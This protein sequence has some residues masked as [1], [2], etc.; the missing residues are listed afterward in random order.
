MFLCTLYF[1]GQQ[2]VPIVNIWDLMPSLK[3]KK[4]QDEWRRRQKTICNQYIASPSFFTL[5]F[6]LTIYHY[7]WKATYKIKNL[8]FKKIDA[9]YK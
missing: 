8:D 3:A 7:P 6:R 4:W 1:R 5:F 9:R 2:N